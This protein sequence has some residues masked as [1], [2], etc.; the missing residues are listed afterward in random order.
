M[1]IDFSD[2]ETSNFIKND[3]KHAAVIKDSVILSESLVTETFNDKSIGRHWALTIWNKS[4]VDKLKNDK[5]IR[6]II[7]G[8]EKCP[9]T[10]KIHYQT[11]IFTKA[12][13]RWSYLKSLLPTASIEKCIKSPEHNIKYCSK[14]NNLYIE[15][16]IKPHKGKKLCNLE[17]LKMSDQDII[18]SLP[19]NQIKN[20]LFLKSNFNNDLNINDLTK[21]MSVYFISGPSGIGKTT[22]H[23]KKIIEDNGGIYNK[24]KYTNGYWSGVNVFG[25]CHVALYDEWRDSHMPVSE[26]INFIDYTKNNMN[27]K[28]IGTHFNNY[29]IIIITT[30]QK[31]KNI[32]RGICDEEPR[33]QWERRINY[34]NLWKEYN[35]NLL[36]D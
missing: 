3:K 8:I 2:S 32:Y 11:Y 27:I 19:L 9:T 33:L 4:D 30:I 15:S 36:D 20:A 25:N 10:D 13:I 14:D 5:H 31:L 21:P 24:V 12:N 34:I 7:S 28:N 1:E 18:Q 22:I 23:A 17:L 35:V 16:G 6:Y 26:F 29:N